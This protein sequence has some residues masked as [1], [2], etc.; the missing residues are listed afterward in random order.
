MANKNNNYT[1]ISF[2]LLH[3]NLK[4]SV[5]PTLESKKGFKTERYSPKCKENFLIY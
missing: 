2:T 3:I 4:Y 5:F 1:K